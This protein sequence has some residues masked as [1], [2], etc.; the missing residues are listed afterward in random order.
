MCTR[1]RAVVPCAIIAHGL[2]VVEATVQIPCDVGVQ[3]L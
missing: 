2:L 3:L 1:H